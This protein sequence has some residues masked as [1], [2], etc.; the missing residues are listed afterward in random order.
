MTSKQL[1]NMVSNKESIKKG[2][3][4]GIITPLGYDDQLHADLYSVYLG[5][6]TWEIVAM[7]RSNQCQ[8]ESLI[9][10]TGQAPTKEEN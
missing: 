2:I 7:Y 10:F 1:F 5:N 9:T 3:E 8:Y 4:Y 6:N